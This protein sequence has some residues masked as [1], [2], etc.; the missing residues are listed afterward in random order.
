MPR[1]LSPPMFPRRMTLDLSEEDHQALRRAAF[2]DEIPMAAM[3][4]ELISMW[5]ADPKLQAKVKTSVLRQAG[6]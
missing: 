1:D 5:R 3:I 2:E 4:R 6:Q